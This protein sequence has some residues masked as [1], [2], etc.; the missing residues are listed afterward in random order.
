[1]FEPQQENAAAYEKA[2]KTQYDAYLQA[3]Q[4]LASLGYIPIERERK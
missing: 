3:D 4:F 1:M 2:K